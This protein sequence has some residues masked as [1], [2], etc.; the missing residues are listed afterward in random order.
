MTSDTL[1]VGSLS[2]EKND[3]KK[4]NSRFGISRRWHLW[5]LG[6]HEKENFHVFSQMAC[7][8]NSLVFYC[9]GMNKEISDFMRNWLP[10]LLNPK[11]TGAPTL[12]L[13]GSEK[14][15]SK[16]VCMLFVIKI[17]TEALKDQ[18]KG[19]CFTSLYVADSNPYQ[20]VS[21]LSF[22]LCSFITGTR[23]TCKHLTKKNELSCLRK[24][25]H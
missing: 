24:F 22:F 11:V 13:H 1:C 6:N 18:N 7:R 23:Q 15:N 21:T 2:E 5:N 8:W 16:G 12:G 3:K 14:N 17:L 10:R 4:E 25:A 9:R 20:V 19:K